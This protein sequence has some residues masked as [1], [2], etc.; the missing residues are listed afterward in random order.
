MK[1]IKLFLDNFIVYGLGSIISKLV[2]FIMIPV[3]TRLLP[4]S[5]Y[6][7]I[8]ELFNTMV[9]F[10]S[11]FATFGM[12]DS[13]FRFFF[14]EEASTYKKEICST[15]FLFVLINSIIV[16][17]IMVSFKTLLSEL[18]FDNK[19]YSYLVVL[20]A[21]AAILNSAHSMVG[22]PTRM[23]NK[24]VRFLA[25]NT[26]G[27]IIAYSISLI[28][29]KCQL[30]ETALP[31]GSIISSGI[32][33]L[34]FGVFNYT[35]F[36][37]RYLKI[38]HL[39]QLL[40]IALPVVP[41][42]FIYWIFNSCD[43]LMITNMLS[44][45][46]T[47]LYS[48]GAKFGA[49]SQLIYTAFSGGWQYFAYSTMKD[50]DQVRTNSKIFECLG[51]VSFISTAFLCSVIYI[52]FKLLFEEAY[53][54][55]YIIAPYLFLAPLLQ[56]LFQILCSQFTIHK[57]TWM[58]MFF[59][60]VSA[61]FNFVANYFLIPV[62]GIEGAALAT[63]L[64]YFI[65]VMISMYASYRLGYFRVGKKF[66]VSASILGGYFV[67]WRSFFS[68]NILTGFVCAVLVTILYCVIYKN[69]I[70]LLKGKLRV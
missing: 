69:D 9:M 20:A 35:W 31:I 40:G 7:G 18:F 57:K 42:T 15:A 50:E 22:A 68:N 32:I 46:A 27:T 36:Q 8:S 70:E 3:I 4:D 26:S 17:F 62:M 41:I 28:L 16:F 61:A 23:Q 53:V 14:E 29:L 56:M 6:Y 65:A 43:K 52:I 67:L 1:K 21:L 25:V 34:T 33:I 48:V 47:G 10:A 5:S 64:G 58:N 51:I 13:M 39:K 66:L 19:R 24:R 49:V 37:F 55:A 38:E 59:L 12:Y 45:E 30:Y 11:T 63:L 2:P 44:V 60:I 54:K